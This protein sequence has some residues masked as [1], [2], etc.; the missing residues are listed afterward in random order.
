ML[1]FINSL[2]VIKKVNYLITINYKFVK[3]ALLQSGAS[4]FIRCI[5][6]TPYSLVRLQWTFVLEDRTILSTHVVNQLHQIC[7][8]LELESS[9]PKHC[10]NENVMYI[11]IKSVRFTAT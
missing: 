4:N 2:K 6:L 3:G 11:L 5:K 7:R 8:E 10:L 9:A 1:V